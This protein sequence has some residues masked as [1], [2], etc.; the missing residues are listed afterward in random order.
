MSLHFPHTALPALDADCMSW[1]PLRSLPPFLPPSFLP[2]SF[3]PLIRDTALLSGLLDADWEQQKK[4]TERKRVG[5]AG[6][7]GGGGGGSCRLAVA[8]SNPACQLGFP[9]PPPQV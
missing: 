9:A 4:G 7:E 5:G 2:P 1:I 8:D 3:S 6:E